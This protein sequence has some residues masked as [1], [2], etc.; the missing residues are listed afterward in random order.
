MTVFE[1]PGER[2][3]VLLC[4]GNLATSQSVISLLR[5]RQRSFMATA[6]LFHAAETVGATLR[7]VM[8]RDAAALARSGANAEASFIVGGQARGEAPRLFMVYPQGNFIEASAQSPLVQLGETRYAQ[9]L[10]DT[11]L[12][13]ATP[14]DEAAKCLLLAMAI[15]L[16]LNVAVGAPI[17]LL[18]YEKDRLRVTRRRRFEQDDA[19]FEHL[20]N[21]WRRGM[22]EL[23]AA[24]PAVEWR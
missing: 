5:E 21:L 9:P 20:S 14:L 10:L 13:H 4:A 8:A 15:T 19:Y 7:E 17:E 16:R 11:V 1:A 2:V 23:C 18:A 22:H 6:T 3:V 24:T 12:S